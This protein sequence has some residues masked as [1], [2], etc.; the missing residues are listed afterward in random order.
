MAEAITFSGSNL[1]SSHH[2]KFPAVAI[3]DD[4]IVVELHQPYIASSNLYY[5]VGSLNR[6]KMKVDWCEL[7]YLDFGRYSKV[8]INNA[9]R[10]VEVHEGA[11]T[12]RVFYRI[13]MVEVPKFGNLNC[14]WEGERSNFLDWGRYPAVAVHDNTVII[15]YDRSYLSY[16]T[17]YCIGTIS[18]DGMDITWGATSELFDVSVAETSVAM[19]TEYIVAVGRGWTRIECCVAHRIQSATV[20]DVDLQPIF[21]RINFDQ[22]GYCP[23]ICL[24]DD[25]HAILVWQSLITRRLICT[26]GRITWG[27]IKNFQETPTI[28]HANKT[29]MYDFGYNPSIAISLNGKHVI[30]EHETNFAKARC[31]LHY[32]TGSLERNTLQSDHRDD[33][34]EQNEGSTPLQEQQQL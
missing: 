6:D 33:E 4:G 28:F 25:H 27:I 2:G 34:S 5:Q 31:T 24:T 21:R 30:E 20:Q 23:N 16:T 26:V 22:L 7:T 10:V 3:N 1:R 14:K 12:R 13:G 29:H 15:T 8:A 11:H 9:N 19:N 17:Y 18:A 32:R